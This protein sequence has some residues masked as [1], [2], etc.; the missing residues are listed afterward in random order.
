[1]EGD[2][3]KWEGPAIVQVCKEEIEIFIYVCHIEGLETSKKV[4][5]RR[6]APSEDVGSCKARPFQRFQ[7]IASIAYCICPLSSQAIRT[8][9]DFAEV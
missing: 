7:N 4:H 6:D 8:T 2:A 5:M 1:M 9:D 3:K